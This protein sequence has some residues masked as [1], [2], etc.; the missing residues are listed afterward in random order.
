MAALELVS[1]VSDRHRGRPLAWDE[2][3]VTPPPSCDRLG[4]FHR[5]Q[6]FRLS[7]RAHGMTFTP[8]GARKTWR[9]W[10]WMSD[11]YAQYASNIAKDRGNDSILVMIDSADVVVQRDAVHLLRE[12]HRFA[13]PLVVALET[14]CPGGAAA[15][16]GTAGRCVPM[17]LSARAPRMAPILKGSLRSSASS[18]AFPDLRYVNGGFVVGRAW[19]MA[20]MWRAIARNEN[21]LSCCHRGAFNPQLRV[22]R[23]ARLHP[24]MVA[25]DTSQRLC[26][27]INYHCVRGMCSGSSRGRH[28]NAA[29]R[30]MWNRSEFQLHYSSR[31]VRGGPYGWTRR[32]CNTHTKQCPVF[33]HVPGQNFAGPQRIYSTIACRNG[34]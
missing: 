30:R 19:A 27:V 9:G 2:R 18:T 21:N 33:V 3:I 29:D 28:L 1:I 20:R 14:G 16:P 32:L 7:A 17:R 11:M 6:L 22:G 10:T 15:D 13:A 31:E 4:P 12:F 25:Y 24:E 5:T 26:A 23:F 8:L 34:V